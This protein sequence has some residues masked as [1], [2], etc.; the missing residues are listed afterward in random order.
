MARCMRCERNYDTGRCSL[1]LI[2]RAK[3]AEAAHLAQVA[4]VLRLGMEVARLR[5]VN[6]GLLE[7]FESLRATHNAENSAA[8]LDAGRTTPVTPDATDDPYRITRGRGA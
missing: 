4:Q 8:L 5:G 6:A 2:D 3:K 1:C 7:A